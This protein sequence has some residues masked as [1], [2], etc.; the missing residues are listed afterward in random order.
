MV[1]DTSQSTDK[2]SLATVSAVYSI[3]SR[4]RAGCDQSHSYACAAGIVSGLLVLILSSLMVMV[5]CFILLRKNYR[6]HQGTNIT[7]NYT[8]YL[9]L[10]LINIG[11]VNFDTRDV[12]YDDIEME[13][14]ETVEPYYP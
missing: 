14:E 13:D 2:R 8:Y 10:L 5:L 7:L 4:E 3:V 12:Q 1:Y 9:Q 11:N 6:R